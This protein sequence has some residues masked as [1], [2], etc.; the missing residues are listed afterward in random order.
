MRLFRWFKRLFGSAPDSAGTASAAP[1]RPSTAET[2]AR[3]RALQSRNAQW[4]DIWAELN[5]NDDSAV[6]ELLL[7]LR[8][9]GL[10]F[11]P[12]DGLRRIELACEEA[13]AG[14]S[15]DV[16][17]ILRRVLGKTD[18]LDKFR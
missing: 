14:P 4:A 1:V 16:G 9:D 7:E 13:V 10:Q 2:L 15:A 12:A 6:R 18:V 11:A 5:P 3:V 17:T 8:N